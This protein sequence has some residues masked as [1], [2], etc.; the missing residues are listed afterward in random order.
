M[1][2]WTIWNIQIHDIP[3][4][5]RFI[6]HFYGHSCTG[7]NKAR[8]RSREGTVY[9][10]YYVKCRKGLDLNSHST[11]LVFPCFSMHLTSKFFP[12]C[13]P[14]LAITR[15]HYRR[16]FNNAGLLA[17]RH[18]RI[19]LLLNLNTLQ[20]VSSQTAHH[21]RHMILP[22]WICLPC[23]TILLSL[24]ITSNVHSC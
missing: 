15:A 3:L 16:N 4:Q 20:S 18:I 14:L 9:I 7:T 11:C 21:K 24:L 10:K 12:L 19:D 13:M 6:V 1:F 23:R 8:E 5:I 17:V 22:I 2:K